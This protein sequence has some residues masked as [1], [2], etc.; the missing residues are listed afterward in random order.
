MEIDVLEIEVDEVFG[1]IWLR[2]VVLR[3][4]GGSVISLPLGIGVRAER[5]WNI[6]KYSLAAASK[7]RPEGSSTASW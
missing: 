3:D 5:Q 4:W 7:T 2:K 6:Q 1:E